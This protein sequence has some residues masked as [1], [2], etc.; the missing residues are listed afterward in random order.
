MVCGVSSLLV[1]TTL[2][3]GVTVISFGANANFSIM[4]V[5][6]ACAVAVKSRAVAIS[7]F[8]SFSSVVD[9]CVD[10][11]K[12]VLAAH[13]GDFACADELAEFV[14]R[15]FHRTGFADAFLSRRRQRI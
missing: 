15:H 1:Q 5:V 12:I 6:S 11:G 4:T 13:E 7:S 9:R 10:Q 3:P 2:V 8:I 14:G